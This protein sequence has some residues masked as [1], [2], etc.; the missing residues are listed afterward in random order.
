MMDQIN[1][2]TSINDVSDMAS[3]NDLLVAKLTEALSDAAKAGVS[4]KLAI[5]TQERLVNLVSF[6][7]LETKLKADALREQFYVKTEDGENAR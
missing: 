6:A 5:K 7:A 4:G 2:E 3:I 1:L